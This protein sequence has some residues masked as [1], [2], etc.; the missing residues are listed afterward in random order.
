L[1]GVFFN[2]LFIVFSGVFFV[3]IIKCK[4]RQNKDDAK[5]DQNEM[6]DLQSFI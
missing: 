3:V 2:Y 5:F 1:L 6:G 4:I